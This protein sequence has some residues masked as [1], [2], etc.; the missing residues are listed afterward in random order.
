M[1]MNN[2]VY[3]SAGGGV[4]GAL[5]YTGR[6]WDQTRTQTDMIYAQRLQVTFKS[7]W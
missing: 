4:F 6:L 3:L 1:K 7:Y 5:K 2:N